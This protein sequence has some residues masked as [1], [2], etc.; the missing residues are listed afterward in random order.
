MGFISFV[1]QDISANKG[2]TKG[3]IVAV[4]FRIANYAAKGKLAKLLLFPYLI[5][6]KIIFEWIIGLEIPYNTQIA[7]GLK[8]YH[9]Q[10]LVI[11][12]GTVIGER[13]ELRHCTTIGNNGK[14]K[15]C[16]IIGNDV[17]IGS[18]VCIIGP[19]KIGDN[20][21]IGAGA[22]VVK[23]IPANSVAVGNPAKVIGQI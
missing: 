14:D 13:V 8:I 7:K 2:N 19:I 12:K 11:N 18:N 6:Y 1:F 16:P 22:V 4:H 23:D 5:F 9:L 21:S 3:K 10:A 15:T 17:K 20:V